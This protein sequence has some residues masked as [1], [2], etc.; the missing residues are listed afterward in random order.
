MGN[1]NNWIPADSLKTPHH[2]EPEW[3]FLFAYTILRSIPN[4]RGGALALLASV[5]ILFFVPLFHSGKFR[6]LAFYPVRQFIF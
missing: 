1:V 5:I 4:K 3:Y 2:I 6:G